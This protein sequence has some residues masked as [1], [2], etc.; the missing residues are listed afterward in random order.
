MGIQAAKEVPATVEIQQHG[1]LSLP[2]VGNIVVPQP[3]GPK[4]FEPYELA[5]GAGWG[6][7]D[8]R[9]GIDETT[10]LDY[11]LKLIRAPDQ[12]CQS[13]SD[14][15][16]QYRSGDLSFDACAVRPLY[17]QGRRRR[18][19]AMWRDRGSRRSRKGPVNAAPRQLTSCARVKHRVTGVLL[20][21]GK[22]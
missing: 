5:S 7:K 19:R 21:R 15:A 17:D 22:C 4:L 10:E 6:N 11:P 12:C 13:D 20:C 1:V 3:F 8:R 18:S 2:R 9:Q 16:A 14:R